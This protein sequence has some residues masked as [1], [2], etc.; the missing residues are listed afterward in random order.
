MVGDLADEYCR[1]DTYTGSERSEVN[2]TINTDRNTLKWREFVNPNTPIPTG[3]NQNPGNGAC[4]GYNQGA[5]PAGWSNDD[6]AGLFEGARYNDNGI[7]RP[8]VNGR[9]R[10]NAPNFCPVCY[11]QM[12]TVMD[13]YH[14]YTFSRS[15]AGDFTGDGKT[16]VVIFNSNSLAL[17]QS[18]GTEVEP[19]WIATGEI[20]LWDDFKPNDHF[21]V[22]DF[23][24]DGRDDLFVF[25]A[26][27]WSM[28]YFAL[29]R[30]TGSGFECIRRFDRELP[31]WDDMKKN[32][33]FYIADFDADGDDD[34]FVFNGLDWSMSY[35]EML[36]ST[37]SNLT[38]V[39]R[40]DRN[41][42]GWGEMRKNDRFY[43]ADINN[44]NREELFIFNGYDWS[45]GYLQLLGSNGSSLYHIRRYDRELPG[46]DDMKKHDRFYVADFNNDGK[47][48]LYVFN[49]LDWSMEYLQ[50][51][52]GTGTSMSNTRRYDGTVPGWDGLAPHDK[53]YVADINGDK[54]DDLYVFNTSDWA[55]E[56]LGVL[57]SYGTS[58]NGGWQSNWIG[59]WNLGSVD[60]L[61]VGN[62]NGG[63]GWDDIFIRNNNWFGLL[64][65]HSYSVHLTAIHPKWIHRHKYHSSGWW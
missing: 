54:R 41:L 45:M 5:V 38:Y 55:T 44:D 8:A 60:R 52:R 25:N 29:L 42:P 49:G 50:M 24:G 23:N 7:Y 27:D 34:V 63:A 3:V 46:W 57:R 22:G 13:P 39:R 56:Y 11:N 10:G 53:F 17:Y 62:F 59:S 51:L 18:V 12:K 4:T 58:L 65:S 32:D 61:L 16:D 33:R 20:P 28:P 2:V 9:M 15:Y 35:L 21:Y 47:D 1:T 48:D 37:G 40:Y 36:R 6:D 19:L 43:V 64:R 26:V 31:G 14:D 30:S